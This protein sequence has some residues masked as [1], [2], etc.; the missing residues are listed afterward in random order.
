MLQVDPILVQ[1]IIG[2]ITHGMIGLDLYFRKK[3]NSQYLKDF[4]SLNEDDLKCALSLTSS[5]K[6]FA[7]PED[8]K[9]GVDDL[10]KAVRN[11]QGLAKNIE[12]ANPRSIEKAVRELSVRINV[13]YDIMMQR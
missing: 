2:R 6:H 1:N 3:E 13:L 12:Q 4:L 7:P 5:S 10:A 8:G 11:A 9:D